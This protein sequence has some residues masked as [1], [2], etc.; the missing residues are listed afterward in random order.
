MRISTKLRIGYILSAVI[1]I[2]AGVIIY[3]S[4]KQMRIKS[5]EFEFVDTISQNVVELNILGNEYL[6]YP[7]ERPRIQWDIKYKVVSHLLAEGKIHASS[8]QS[9]LNQIREDLGII[10]THFSDLVSLYATSKPIIE[11]ELHQQ[12]QN[13]LQSLMLLKSE[14]VLSNS[15]QL[16]NRIKDELFYLQRFTN[17][18]SIALIAATALLSVIIGLLVGRS[19]TSPIK[20]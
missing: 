10:R 1:V 13:R 12:I 4:F 7:E 2:F 6:M 5:R 8:H 9:L 14:R 16:K 17:W 3:I 15:V 20:T 18:M 11:S 19:I